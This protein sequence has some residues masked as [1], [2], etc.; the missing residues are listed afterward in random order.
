MKNIEIP[1]Q[2]QKGKR[3][4]FFEMIPG[5]TSWT[6][7]LLPFLL[8]WLNPT[9]GV[10]LIL[11]YLLIWFA[12]SMG[13]T[14]RSVQGLRVINKQMKFPW[15]QM[16]KEISE[17]KVS[18]PS[19]HIPAWH[20]ENI[21]RLQESPPIVEPDDVVHAII[22]AAYNETKEVLGPTVQYILASEY[23]MKKV[24]LVFAYEGRDGAQSEQAVLELVEEYGDKFM[25]T[26]AS[27]HP[28]TEGEVRGKGGNITYAGRRLAEYLEKQN[29]DPIRVVVTTLD[30]D[31]RPHKY[32]LPALTYIYSLAPDP[33]HVSFQPVPM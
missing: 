16:L 7:L 15:D 30:S 19:K 8:G 26:M 23:D 33:V 31:N 2:E 20:Y 18:Q 10:L 9:L 12:K 11:A 24:I 1:Y 14:L 22:I 5:I 25:K 6:I 17:R 3:Y 27:K 28:L 13:L 32:Y 21:R 29:I 4:R